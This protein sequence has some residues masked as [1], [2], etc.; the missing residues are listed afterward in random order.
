MYNPRMRVLQAACHGQDVLTAQ[1]ALFDAKTF[2]SDIDGDFG[3]HMLAAVEA[4]QKQVGLP[5]TGVID[6]K[7]ASALGLSDPAPV[8]SA[9]PGITPF[10]VSP[11][12]PF[13]NVANIEA[14]LPYILNALNAAGLGDRD[15]IL[16][17]LATIAAETAT[18]LPISEQISDLNTS[19][20]GP[21]FD[22]YDNRKDL[23]NTGPP[24]G[25]SFRGRGFIQLTGR[26][27]FQF[28]GNNIGLS[29]QLIQKPTLAHRQ[30]IAAN[31]LASFLKVNQ[32][33][34]RDAIRAGNFLAARKAVNGGENGAAVF[35]TTYSE[36]NLLPCMQQVKA[37][38]A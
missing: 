20:G 5:Q 36:G 6:A 11:L 27:N 22:L 7:T 24:D 15:M 2:S 37:S 34:I 29:T 8:T 25:S 28:H 3:P 14:N 30:D 12:F 13:T 17:A 35:E 26:A 10:D 19:H 4:F 9:I 32:S 38:V 21:P 1:C 18:F 31:L 23:G 16:M 33:R